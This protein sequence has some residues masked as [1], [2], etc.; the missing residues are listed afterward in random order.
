[1]R[2]G[3]ARLVLVLDAAALGAAAAALVIVLGLPLAARRALGPQAVL[4]L[5]IAVG[6]LVTAAGAMLLARSVGSAVERILG[7]ADS[8][9]RVAPGRVA[10][11]VV[12]EADPLADIRNL[13][14]TGLVFIRG[15]PTDP[16]DLRKEWCPRA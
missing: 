11:L 3:H 2:A 16:R 7:A 12:V 14:R 15:N 6:L 8:L 13:Q 4:A 1:M 10:D 9:G 5:G